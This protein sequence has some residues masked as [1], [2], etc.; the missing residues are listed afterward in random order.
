M[1]SASQCFSYFHFQFLF[2][3][4]SYR[5][6]AAALAAPK[7]KRTNLYIYICIYPYIHIFYLQMSRD[8]SPGSYRYVDLVADCDDGTGL[9]ALQTIRGAS[10]D[11]QAVDSQQDG[12]QNVGTPTAA[13]NKSSPARAE[14]QWADIETKKKGGVVAR[15]LGTPEKIRARS[16]VLYQEIHSMIDR[17]EARA[18]RERELK[19]RES[20]AKR[21]SQAGL[22]GGRHS[23]ARSTSSA[24]SRQG[25]AAERRVDLPNLQEDFEEA[26][27]HHLAAAQ[28]QR[29][30]FPSS[31]RPSGY[32]SKDPST[33]SYRFQ[34]GSSD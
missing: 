2:F 3:F 19:H 22:Q 7:S 16:L 1:I 23:S 6:W 32:S 12:Q 11:D 28:D 17:H 31:S 33:F 25:S 21:I 9:A 5:S 20:R 27:R 13:A 30:Y 10:Y 8:N 18:G 4:V 26:R 34:N 15:R 24:R 29:T 14:V